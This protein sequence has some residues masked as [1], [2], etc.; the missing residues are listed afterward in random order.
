M[1]ASRAAC[2]DRG[3]PEEASVEVFKAGLAVISYLALIDDSY[4]PFS[5][6][7]LIDAAALLYKFRLS[8]N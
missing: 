7:A 4:L 5:P 1:L 6:A 8:M 2:Y 3:L